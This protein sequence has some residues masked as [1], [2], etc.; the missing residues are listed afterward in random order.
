MKLS[1]FFSF[2]IPEAIGSYQV[3]PERNVGI[4]IEKNSIN[5]CFVYLRGKKIVVEQAFTQLLP[6]GTTADYAERVTSTLVQI[7]KRIGSYDRLLTIL[8]SSI[9]FT[10]ELTLPFIT[11]EKI[12]LVL[13]HEIASL[14]PVSLD[15]V[16][17]DFAITQ[18][19]QDQKNAQVLAIAIQKQHI[20]EHLS[21]F[22]AA[23]MSPD[24]ITLDALALYNLMQYTNITKE[25]GQ[26]V[27][28]D[29][30]FATTRIIIIENNKLQ[31]MRTLSAGISTIAKG[32]ST[33]LN[34]KAGEAL[35][36]LIRFGLNNPSDTNYQMMVSQELS[37]FCTLIN[38]TLVAIPEATRKLVLIDSNT[39]IPDLCTQ[40]AACLNI[41]CQIITMRSFEHHPTIQLTESVRDAKPLLSLG[42]VLPFNE[43]YLVNFRK[44]EF[45]KSHTGEF[46]TQAI[47]AGVLVIV[48]FASLLFHHYRQVHILRG[49][50]ESARRA[51]IARLRE[52]LGIEENF[53][54]VA[55]AL[56]AAK[57]IV[58][59]QEATWFAFSAQT[60][61]SFL[62]YLEGLSTVIDK[63]ALGFKLKRL[64]LT[65]DTITIQGQVK[66]WESG[67][68]QA[69]DTLEASLRA[70]DF[71]I[72]V[73][74]FQDT[75]FTEQ[76]RVK[77]QNGQAP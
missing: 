35:D 61:S 57:T 31:T 25:P 8:P 52:S 18:I 44:D 4:I 47:I 63:E 68:A 34:N 50:L 24:V 42:L 53:K 54:R 58:D 12:A 7:K 60:R 37:D 14:L 21:Y 38:R 6:A 22:E 62:H 43:N 77:K 3:I 72:E 11:R 48:L 26:Y 29:V 76:L 2:F 33:R 36:M 69:L 46:L 49:S 9:A 64:V 30:A 75:V 23:G 27:I 32:L 19:N 39:M 28:V 45:K 74:R 13:E 41:P 10:K 15:Q 40:L 16:V 65:K 59:K 67:G 71:F 73:P 20:A 1:S 56:E 70:T 66:G 5:V 17:I 51:T 55:D